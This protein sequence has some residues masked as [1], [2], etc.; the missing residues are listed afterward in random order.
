MR[1]FVTKDESGRPYEWMDYEAVKIFACDTM[2][3]FSPSVI[4]PLKIGIFS[5]MLPL[6]PFSGNACAMFLGI[7][8][9]RFAYHGTMRN[10]EG[11]PRYDL[12]G[13]ICG[14]VS[15]TDAAYARRRCGELLAEPLRSTAAPTPTPPTPVP[16]IAEPPPVPGDG[17]R[18]S[19][20]SRSFL[21]AN[22]RLLDERK[23]LL[24]KQAVAVAL[25]QELRENAT[26]MVSILEKLGMLI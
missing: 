23:E 22:A 26:R 3:V 18:L 5:D 12:A 11:R 20:L 19:E 1:K 24:A 17:K 7:W 4:R 2:P 25:V 16:I 15:R 14:V 10:S 9:E 21:E 13:A 6:M 8:C